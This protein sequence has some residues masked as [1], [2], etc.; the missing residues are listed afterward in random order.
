MVWCGV[1]LVW[2][3]VVWCC[4]VWYG[5]VWYGMAWC[6]W[7]CRRADNVVWAGRDATGKFEGWG[8]DGVKSDGNK[9]SMPHGGS[10]LT[11]DVREATVGS[12]GKLGE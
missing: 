7:L 5:L 1:V 10:M 12:R 4:L 8:W 6:V 2:C 3:D 9:S 11:G